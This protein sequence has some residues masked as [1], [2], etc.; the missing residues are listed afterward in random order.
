MF[1]DQFYIVAL[2]WLVLQLTGSGLA[3]GTVMMAAA[4]PRAVFMLMGGAIT[5]RFSPRTVL[6]STA[7]A[8]TVLVAAVGGL[9]WTHIIHLWHLYALA[10]AFGVADAFSYP[11]HS[12]LIPS[13]VEPDQLPA[14]NAL[15][16]GSAQA[17]T[18][19]GP[20]PAGLVI[21]RWGIA[22][23]FFVDAVSFMFI[24]AAIWRLPGKSK[25]TPVQAQAAQPMGQAIQE[26]L[27]YVWHDPPI[28]AL[29]LLSTAIN[30]GLAGPLS[31]GIATLANLRMRSPTA[32]GAMF[33]ALS[34]GALIGML[35]AGSLRR[36]ARLGA[37]LLAYT[38]VLG[39]AMA[40]LGVIRPFWLTI[41]VLA[42]MGLGSGFVNVHLT[43]WFQARVNR[44]LLGRSVSVLLFAAVG[45]LPVSFAMAGVLVQVSL[46]LLFVASG[47][48]VLTVAMVAG[49]TSG[50][51]S[52][53]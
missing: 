35:L 40:A 4:I 15:M 27:R 33:A 44:A 17:T 13:V 36:P 22:E 11:A 6:I 38:T 21:K 45:L 49:A 19:A 18:I 53:E 51:K 28:R 42:S 1:G 2:P 48:L 32:L 24:I 8:R 37:S 20:A 5:D 3:L 50:L 29:M 25:A 14:A 7:S 9:A 12:A 30:L 16:Q 41:G 23:A 52:I 26:G 34:A 10:F 39:I 46:P 47:A 31:V 43:S